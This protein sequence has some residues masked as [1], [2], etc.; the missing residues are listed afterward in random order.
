MGSNDT[1]VLNVDRLNLEVVPAVYNDSFTGLHSLL[2][3]PDSSLIL[4][5]RGEPICLELKYPGTRAPGPKL[6]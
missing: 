1:C 4:A 6:R 5:W 3:E 2:T